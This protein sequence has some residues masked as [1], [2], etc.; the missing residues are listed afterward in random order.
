MVSGNNRFRY[1]G[2]SVKEYPMTESRG[3]PWK[4]TIPDGRPP[5]GAWPGWW[6]VSVF[7][8]S[9]IGVFR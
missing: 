9:G 2:K 6:D 3:A 7:R 4:T 8:Y 1:F 5:W